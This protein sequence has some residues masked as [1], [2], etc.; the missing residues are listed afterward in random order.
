MFYL[1]HCSHRLLLN[2]SNTEKLS[3]QRLMRPLQTLRMEHI[4]SKKTR[5][6][7]DAPEESGAFIAKET[8]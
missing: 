1:T 7:S 3:R 8:I 2:S 5:K 4:Q 6:I